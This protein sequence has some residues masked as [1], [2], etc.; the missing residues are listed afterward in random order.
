MY[1]SVALTISASIALSA[2]AQTPGTATDARSD[3]GFSQWKNVYQS[4]IEAGHHHDYDQALSLLEKSWQTAENDQERGLAADGLGDV[5]GRLGRV[6]EAKTW[7][8]RAIGAFSSD[9]RQ[10]LRLAAVTA[11]LA[12]LERGSGDYS[13]AEAVL[14]KALHSDVCDAES[15]AFLRNNLAGLLREEGRGAEARRRGAPPV[16]GN[17]GLARPAR[18]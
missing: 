12:A 13:A 10:S 1:V 17:S 6:K 11:S 4:A 16:R 5:S 2:F 15:R 8:E 9:P 18:K 14:Q 3:N 7:L